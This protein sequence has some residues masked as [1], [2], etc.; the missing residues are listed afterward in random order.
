MGWVVLV[1]WLLYLEGWW[2]ELGSRKSSQ[3]EE[4]VLVQ[5]LYAMK[6][7]EHGAE[8]LLMPLRG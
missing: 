7:K 6:M 5:V 2:S 4:R 1:R 3:L 8:L